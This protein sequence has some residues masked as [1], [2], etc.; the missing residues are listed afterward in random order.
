MGMG[1]STE[2]HLILEAMRDL[3]DCI[4]LI[5]SDS[6]TGLQTEDSIWK[7]PDGEE[8]RLELSKVYKQFEAFVTRNDV[9][10]VRAAKR[11]GQ[12]M[13]DHKLPLKI[14]HPK[15]GTGLRAES[16]VGATAKRDPSV[17]EAPESSTE[18]S[19]LAE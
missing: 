3:V 14:H 11:R 19:R 8:L 6:G 18:L 2:N 13:T 12:K 15:P 9:A 10:E 5:R 16:N 7:I 4:K 1:R 17:H